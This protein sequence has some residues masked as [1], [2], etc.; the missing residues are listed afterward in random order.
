MELNARRRSMTPED[1]AEGLRDFLMF[2]V[3]AAV[4]VYGFLSAGGM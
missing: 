1:I 3:V 4:E 2:A